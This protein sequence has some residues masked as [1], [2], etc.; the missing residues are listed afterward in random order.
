MA[1]S[2]L[3][4]Q[5]VRA[6]FN[7]A[8]SAMR[9]AQ[10]GFSQAGTVFGQ[11]RKSILDEEQRAVENTYKEKIFDENVRQF[12]LTHGLNVDRLRESQ[13]QFDINAAATAARDAETA[14]HH[15][16]VENLQQALFNYR[17]DQD[18]L[19]RRDF[20]AL[21][22]VLNPK[23]A[24]PQA[25][26]A[27]LAA[28]EE[29]N[30]P[31]ITQVSEYDKAYQQLQKDKQALVQDQS[32]L[33][34]MQSP[35]YTQRQAGAISD[36]NRQL[37]ELESQEEALYKQ[38]AEN[39]Q[40]GWFD[41]RTTGE[42]YTRQ[43]EL[44]KRIEAIQQQKDQ[45]NEELRTLQTDHASTLADDIAK[46][47]A[48]LN[49]R[50]QQL[51]A[52][53]PQIEAMRKALADTRPKA[54]PNASPM[55]EEA[56]LVGRM[57]NVAPNERVFAQA[58]S[59]V[60]GQTATRTAQQQKLQREQDLNYITARANSFT[61]MTRDQ[62]I[63]MLQEL[64]PLAATDSRYA[65][66]LNYFTEWFQN[67]SQNPTD[68][69]NF[70]LQTRAALGDDDAV[71]ALQ[72]NADKGRE[73]AQEQSKAEIKV[74]SD[75]N[76][77]WLKVASSGEYN[78][79]QLS[80]LETTANIIQ[81]RARGALNQEVIVNRKAL[82]DT[83]LAKFGKV[84]NWFANGSYSVI[85]SGGTPEDLSLGGMASEYRNYLLDK[86]VL[87]RFITTRTGKPLPPERLRDLV[88]ALTQES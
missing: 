17:K 84:K 35:E 20:Q 33:T 31:Q 44:E 76:N 54:L 22:D 59:H 67:P 80:G 68:K 70:L 83:L 12:G 56:A 7:D 86:N 34:K 42:K 55:S 36:K 75:E 65:A 11:L 19:T 8:N 45:I 51:S 2:N 37:A 40:T 49:T 52:Q 73:I 53:T 72:S 9:N 5:Q 50:T 74:R 25:Q 21:A 32:R 30:K 58:M 24:D 88:N 16:V 1:G 47:Q 3:N 4:W 78:R 82:L 38:I 23:A 48:M 57:L 26:A 15:G 10:T 29:E 64:Q 60:L 77:S 62:Q 87:A 6:D 43:T 46:R 79:D 18:A 81:D 13:Y 85:D 69:R 27:A 71:K 61:G 41:F 66:A 14:R 39:K 28:W 63:A